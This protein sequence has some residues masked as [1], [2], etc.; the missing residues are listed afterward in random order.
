MLRKHLAIVLFA[1]ATLVACGKG[2]DSRTGR[3][4]TGTA[5]TNDM[6]DQSDQMGA[7]RQRDMDTRTGDIGNGTRSRPGG[8]SDT[9]VYG[10]NPGTGSVPEETSPGTNDQ[11]TDNTT[12]GGTGNP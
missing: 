8:E 9:G 12:G 5:G 6:N 4:Q 1:A 2:Y 10:T 3:N 11:N 7:P